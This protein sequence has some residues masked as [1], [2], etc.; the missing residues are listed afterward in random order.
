MAVSS[1]GGSS[2]SSLYGSRNVLSG[3]ASGMD[4][5]AMIENMVM[6]TKKQNHS[7][8]TETAKAAVEAGSVPQYQ[9]SIGAAFHQIYLVHLLNQSDECEFLQAEYYHYSR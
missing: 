2:A 3:L 6:G 1:V 7:A 9:R 4:T 5:E 8:A